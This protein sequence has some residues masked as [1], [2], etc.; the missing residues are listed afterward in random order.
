MLADPPQKQLHRDKCCSLQRSTLRRACCNCDL[1]SLLH[2]R[3]RPSKPSRN[4]ACLDLRTNAHQ[5]RDDR[6][7]RRSRCGCCGCG[8]SGCD[9]RTACRHSHECQERCGAIVPIEALGPG[10]PGPGTFA[11][12]PVLPNSRPGSSWP[13][14]I[15]YGQRAPR[16]VHHHHGPC[17]HADVCQRSALRPRMPHTHTVCQQPTQMNC[18]AVTEHVA[19][20]TLGVEDDVPGAHASGCSPAR[21]N[22]TR[23]RKCGHWCA[24]VVNSRSWSEKS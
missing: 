18:L 6:L 5:T 4:V 3:G 1:H 13:D 11:A 17:L 23:H 20:R 24:V 14:K 22:K 9:G 10:A 2:G 16:M 19:Q 12:L 21:Q 8:R 15:P 7:G